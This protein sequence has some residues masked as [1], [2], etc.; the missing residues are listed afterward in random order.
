MPFRLTALL[1]V[2]AMFLGGTGLPT[3]AHAHGGATVHALELLHGDH[4]APSSDDG[5][6]DQPVHHHCAVTI[7]GLAVEVPVG[8]IRVTAKLTAGLAAPMT[9]LSQAPP[10]EPPSV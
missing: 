4:E 6:R 7:G 3:M 9:S 8:S 1:M 2:L 5:E 10:V